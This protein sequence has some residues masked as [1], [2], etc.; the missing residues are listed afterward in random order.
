[1][2]LSTPEGIAEN[3]RT[4]ATERS[5][6]N[7][8]VYGQIL[9]KI[10]DKRNRLNALALRE[11]DGDLSLEINR[12]RGE[13]N[14]LLN[15]EEIYW[16]QRAKAHWLKEDDRN[17]KFFHAQASERRKQNTIMDIWDEHGRWCDEEDSIA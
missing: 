14:A 3:L 5:R 11:R 9:K 12:L 15:D 7:S 13:I 6:W 8:A 17:T 16:E 1:M 4:C 2:D 10:Q